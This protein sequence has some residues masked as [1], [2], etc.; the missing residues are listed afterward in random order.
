MALM[1]TVGECEDNSFI[2]LWS[3][4]FPT[5]GG[6]EGR[7]AAAAAGSGRTPLPSSSSFE[8]SQEDEEL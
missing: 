5:N 2:S 3:G 7:A 8:A 6:E 1:S 4:E